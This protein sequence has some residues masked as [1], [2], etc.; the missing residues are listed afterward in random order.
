MRVLLFAPGTSVHSRRFTNWLLQHGCEVVF[1]DGKAPEPTPR[2]RFQYVPYPSARAK[3]Y[4]Q[5]M[6]WKISY[7]LEL[8][9]ILAKLRRLAKQYRPDV[10]HV[11]WVDYRAYHCAEARLR[12]LALTVWGSDVNEAL[13]PIFD[14]FYRQN[15]GKALA[16]AD[17]VF[18]DSPDMPEKCAQLAGRPVRTELLPLGI[19][20]ARFRPAPAAAE[21]WRKLLAIPSDAKVL[22]SNR[23]FG[24][25]Y[26]HDLILQAFAQARS[27]FQTE[28]VLLFKT[29]SGVADPVSPVYAQEIRQLAEQLGVTPWVRWM[30]EVPYDRLPSLYSLA[31]AVVNYPAMDAFPV[32]FLEAAAA[33]CP[34]ITVRLPS[35]HGT[36]ADKYFRTVEPWRVA[37]LAD[38][39]AEVVNESPGQRQQGL[40]E[41]RRVVEQEFD[42]AVSAQRLLNVYRSLA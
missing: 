18:V 3:P 37:D 10:A 13:L 14:R 1:V 36:F 34:V 20:T 5:W 4:Y 19:D 27:R 11:H 29:Y 7:R 41:A 15:I 6:G 23:A 31:D 33:E 17:V 24:K 28:A 8:W 26:N 2:E 9:S 16:S 35:Y 22:F 12:P 39:M 21:E 32:S 25:K 42:E 38:R 40:S 30:D